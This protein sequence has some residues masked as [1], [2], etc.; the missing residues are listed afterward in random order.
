MEGFPDDVP[1]SAADWPQGCREPRPGD[2]QVFIPQGFGLGAP[3]IIRPYGGPPQHS[4]YGLDEPQAHP[5]LNG[6]LAESSGGTLYFDDNTSVQT[7]QETLRLMGVYE[8]L[9]YVAFGKS[10]SNPMS[11]RY[12]DQMRLVTRSA[13]ASIFGATSP[14]PPPQ[15][16]LH[17]PAA[18][19]AFITAQRSKWNDG[20][21]FSSKLAGTAGGDGDWAKESLAFGFHVENTYWGIYRVWSRSWLVTK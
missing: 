5:F 14:E 9:D 1:L 19:C 7:L 11:E 10:S 6:P 20:Y 21:A 13:L 3:A 16:T 4:Y 17:A 18:I 15:Q 12:L 2:L 8:T